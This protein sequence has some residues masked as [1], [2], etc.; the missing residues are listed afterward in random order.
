MVAH[1]VSRAYAISTKAGNLQVRLLLRCGQK[2][3]VEV[4]NVLRF[5]LMAYDAQ[6]RLPC[7]LDDQLAP[8]KVNI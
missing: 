8:V 1:E 3:E 4:I 6:S 2:A 5:V 7:K